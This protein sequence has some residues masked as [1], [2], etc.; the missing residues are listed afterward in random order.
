MD[1]LWIFFT[2]IV[3][4]A[5]SSTLDEKRHVEVDIDAYSRSNNPS[6]EKWMQMVQDELTSLDT[7]WSIHM[8]RMQALQKVRESLMTRNGNDQEKQQNHHDMKST[9]SSFYP[10]LF[11]VVEEFMIPWK[12]WQ[13]K[14]PILNVQWIRVTSSSTLL[15]VWTVQQVHFYDMTGNLLLVHTLT[16]QAI[17]TFGEMIIHGNQGMMFVL[18]GTHMT[19]FHVT[20]AHDHDILLGD[21]D[22]VMSGEGWSMM[23]QEDND[24]LEVSDPCSSSVPVHYK[25]HHRAALSCGSS[26]HFMENNGTI[27]GTTTMEEDISIMKR[28]GGQL[29]LG[30]G[31]SLHFLHA[32]SGK[33]MPLSL[34]CLTSEA[35]IT[36]IAVDK[37]RKNRIYAGTENGDIFILDRNIGKGAKCQILYRLTGN[38]VTQTDISIETIPGYLLSF[39]SNTMYVH[40]ITDEGPPPLIWQQSYPTTGS[41]LETTRTSVFLKTANQRRR[42]SQGTNEPIMVVYATSDGTIQL[43]QST[44]P[45]STHSYD[46]DW[47]RTPLIIIIFVAVIAYQFSKK[48]SQGVGPSDAFAGMDPS[49]LRHLQQKGKSFE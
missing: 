48:S 35:T 6:S 27:I 5:S 28:I 19:K 43:Y 1:Y 11:E 20:L 49:I 4:I 45:H 17:M 47:I 2:C 25:G 31:P 33:P 8:E 23:L 18:S 41:P 32:E 44:L 24:P 42:N 26:V 34:T 22:S 10:P 15:V 3:A 40:N 13:L 38:P 29:V 16:M 21:K 46:I 36:A 39:M 14:D 30:Q 9:S 7:A 37:E 12:S